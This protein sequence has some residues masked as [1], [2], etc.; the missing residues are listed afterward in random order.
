[1]PCIVLQPLCTIFVPATSCNLP[2]LYWR[3]FSRLCW[4]LHRSCTYYCCFFCACISLVSLAVNDPNNVCVSDADFCHQYV[5]GP[6]RAFKRYALACFLR[7]T[8]VHLLLYPHNP[9][10]HVALRMATPNKLQ[11]LS[12]LMATHAVLT[13]ADPHL[14]HRCP[15]LSH[16]APLD[17]QEPYDQ[18]CTSAA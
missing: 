15:A 6:H 17:Y 18:E 8:L 11:T 4:L 9:Q 10:S 5:G 13:N 1:M 14:I 3:C 2:F 16:Q 7:T 12:Y